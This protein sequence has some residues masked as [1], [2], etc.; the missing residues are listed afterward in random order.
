M[1]REQI[2]ARLAEIGTMLDGIKAGDE[3]FTD[4]QLTQIEDLDAEYESLDKQL[5]A[6]EKVEAIQSRTTTSKG[7]QTKP[8]DPAPSNVVRVTDVRDAKDKFGG[9]DSSGDFLMAV[10]RASAGDIDKRFQNVA[11]EKNGEDGGFLVPEDISTAILKKLESNE[12]LMS[13]AN[14]MNVS[15]S[16]MSLTLDESQPWNQGIQAYWIAEG[17]AYTET[18]PKFTTAQWRLHKLGAMVKPTDE[19]LEDAVGLESYIKIAAPSAIMY[20]LNSAIIAGDGVGKPQ[21][22]LNS[23]FT[24]SVAKKSGQAADTVVADNIINMYTRMLPASR[25]RAKWYINA[26]VEPQLL[27][28]TDGDGNYIYLAPGS[29]LN[30]TPY[31]LLLGRPVVPMLSGLPQLGD[32]GDIL[33]ADPS[34]YYMI[35]KAGGIKAATSIH[36]HFDRDITAFKFTFRVDGRV[37]FSSPVTTEFGGYQMS[38]FVKLEDRA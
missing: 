35:R 2:V 18:K 20:K 22:F 29:Q 32:S 8:N 37:P 34:Y 15:G 26:G 21:G 36:L 5:K 14:V 27:G 11:Y 13:E 1:K 12:S 6:L 33:F 31:G 38:S 9:F 25:A 10:R 17:A 24:I 16:T 4:E 30:Q 7:R 3:G 28:M 23:P 19:L